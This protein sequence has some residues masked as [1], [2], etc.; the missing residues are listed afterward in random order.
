MRKFLQALVFAVVLLTTTQESFAQCTVRSVVKHTCQ[1]YANGSIEL[2]VEGAA[3]FRFQ[4]SNGAEEQSQENL[5]AGS[6]SVTV[7]D[8][9]GAKATQHVKIESY[10]GLQVRPTV[11]GSR[12]TVQ[13]S[14]GRM[15]YKYHWVPLSGSRQTTTIQP[16]TQLPKGSYLLVVEDG[17]GCSEAKRFKVN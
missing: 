14:G 16:A 3:P 9:K 11:E 4:W 10:A 13:V 17:N 12:V 15:P 8:A 1:A 7:T 2:Q 5:P 6:Y